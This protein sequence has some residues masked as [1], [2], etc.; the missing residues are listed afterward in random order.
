[1]ISDITTEISGS[2][3]M[4]VFGVEIELLLLDSIGGRGYAGCDG[5]FSCLYLLLM[6]EK[7]WVGTL[8]TLHK[9]LNM[10]G[11]GISDVKKEQ[12]RQWSPWKPD[13]NR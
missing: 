8:V 1:M 9:G 6:K 3:H 5:E 2:R 7:V 13:M 10:I 12:N 4:N 11:I